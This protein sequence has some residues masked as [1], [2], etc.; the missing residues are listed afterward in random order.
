MAKPSL[1]AKIAA[2][3]AASNAA[4]E[5][6]YVGMFGFLQALDYQ[7]VMMDISALIPTRNHHFR[8]HSDEMLQQLALDI[9]KNGLQNP[10][11]ARPIGEGRYEVLAGNNRMRA[12]VFN[13]ENK[14]PCIIR[15][16]D[17]D[18]AALIITGTNLNQ[19]QELLPSEL[20]WAYRI[21][22][23]ALAHQGKRSASVPMGQAGVREGNAFATPLGP[24]ETSRQTVARINAV[25]E[26]K[27]Q[28]YIRLTYLNENLLLKVDE[29][30]LPL[31]AAIPLS[32]YSSEEQA[33]FYRFFYEDR[34]M[35]PSVAFS[36]SIQKTLAPGSVSDH[37]LKALLKKEAVV[38]SIPPKLVLSSEKFYEYLPYLSDP[39]TL[40]TLFL[41]FLSVRFKKN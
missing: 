19:R 11:I 2:R 3:R 18:E 35:K 30:A 14:I 1:S 4:L 26:H 32:Y 36:E 24:A 17:D 5:A 6:D 41:E 21:Q 38:P 13:K 31:R 8:M 28:R 15:N 16:V 25:N 20:G 10:I 7:V 40:E 12:Y 33:I 37:S 23:E 34:M 9:Q 27:I 39:T 29:K 22:M